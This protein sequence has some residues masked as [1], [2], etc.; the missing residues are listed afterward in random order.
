MCLPSHFSHDRLLATPWTTALQAPLSMGFSRQE[1]WSGLPSP[2]PGALPHP[3]ME[4]ASPASPVAPA[5]AGELFTTGGPREA[6]I[7]VCGYGEHLVGVPLRQRLL[8]AGHCSGCVCVNMMS[9]H[10]ISIAMISCVQSHTANK[11]S[12]SSSPY[13]PDSHWGLWVDDTPEKVSV[14]GREAWDY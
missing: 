1:Y 10:E 13:R 12:H 4:P 11:W 2:P 3:G 8:G 5:L 14:R 6:C 9:S 7:L